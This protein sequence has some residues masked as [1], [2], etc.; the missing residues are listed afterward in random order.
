MPGRVIHPWRSVVAILSS[1][2]TPSNPTIRT[3]RQIVELF[4]AWHVHQ[5]ERPVK[6]SALPE[7]VRVLVDPQGR[8]RQHIAA[9]RAQLTGTR[10]GGFVLTRQEAAGKWGVATYSFVRTGGRDLCP[11]SALDTLF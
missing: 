1:G 11:G 7:P 5:G 6:A 3:R 8:G 4:D 10:A 9:R 2:L